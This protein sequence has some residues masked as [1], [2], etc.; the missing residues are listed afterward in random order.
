M[1]ESYALKLLVS[2]FYGRFHDL[3]PT[4][5]GFQ[6]GLQQLWYQKC[7]R[8]WP[9]S[10]RF[11]VVCPYS[12]AIVR[13]FG[14]LVGFAWPVRPDTCL[15]LM[16]KNSSFSRL[17]AVFMNYCP[18]VWCPRAICNN[19]KT[20][21][22][23]EG[24]RKTCRFRVL[25]PFSRAISHSFAVVVGFTCLRVMTKNL[26]FSVL[27]M[28]SWAIA[29]SFGVSRRFPCLSVMTKKSSFSCFMDVVMSYCPPFCGPMVIYNDR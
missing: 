1:F 12:W 22:M 10:C 25:R 15:R 2:A 3:L 28:F 18:Q 5:L 26:L 7:L 17:M 24:M 8:A 19:L 20:R 4:V 16:T 6:L 29:H 14:G 13:S 11:R 27:Y 23:F 9:R 21:Y